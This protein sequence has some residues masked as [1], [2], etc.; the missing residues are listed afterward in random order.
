MTEH[1]N[2]RGG[3]RE[4]PSG[5]RRKADPTGRKDAEQVAM[6]EERNIAASV[7][8]PFD[9]SVRTLADLL[10]GL[11]IGYT[12]VPKV[13]VRVSLPDLGSGKAFIIAVV[14]LDE[15]GL[16]LSLSSVSGKAAGFFRALQRTGEHK[17][18]RALFQP[19]FDSQRLSFTVW[20]QRDIGQARVGTG[21]APGRLSVSD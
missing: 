7:R 19:L 9:H 17:S 18:K 15:V 16:D 12:V 5:S 1:A 21:K 14:P 10:N 8:C 11:A 13:P 4:E 2:R 3:E 20:R 6:S